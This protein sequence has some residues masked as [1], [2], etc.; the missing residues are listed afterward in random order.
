MDNGYGSCRTDV[1]AQ[2]AQ[3]GSQVI[4]S[5]RFTD[6]VGCELPIQLAAM[7]GVGTT[8]LAA[9]VVAAGGLGMVPSGAAPAPGACGANFLMPFQPALDDIS[10]VASQSRVVEF[11]Y[12]HPRR[13]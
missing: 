12:D 3:P 13:D 9:A 5:T 6:L 1:R 2:G 4:T 8:E 7:G 11:F 10:K